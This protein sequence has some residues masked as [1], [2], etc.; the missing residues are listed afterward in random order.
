MLNWDV[1]WI[2]KAESGFEMPVPDQLPAFGDI[3]NHNYPVSQ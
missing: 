1:E 2:I 3:S